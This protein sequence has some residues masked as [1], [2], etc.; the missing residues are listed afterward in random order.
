LKKYL[1]VYKPFLVFLGSFFLAY[2]GLTI[3]YQ[4]YL[5]S[6]GPNQIDSITTMVAHNTEQIL[7]LF[8]ADAKA[9]EAKSSLFIG[10]LYNQKYVA[11]IIEGCNAMSVIILFVAF[12]VAFSG[13]LKPTLMYVFGGSI[14]IYILNVLR[15]VLLCILLYRFPKQEHFLHGVLF[16]L[17]IYSVVFILWVIWVN[18]FSKYA[19]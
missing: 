4:T 8:G 17:F 15:I 18:K 16:P 2:I 12:I 13:K 5:G 3:L 14:F 19:K 11:R 9:V 1:I 7:Q 10:L 6:F